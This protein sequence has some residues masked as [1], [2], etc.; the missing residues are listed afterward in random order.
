[1]AYIENLLKSATVG[2]TPAATSYFMRPT[3][4]INVIVL[5]TP[6]PLW[7]ATGIAIGAGSYASVLTH[8]LIFP[9]WA[10]DERW[11]HVGASSVALAT[12]AGGNYEALYAMNSAVPSQIGI[13]K[14][15]GFAI[16]STIA[17]TYIYNSFLRPITL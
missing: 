6:L 1:M 9:A 7:A 3:A 5:K 14:V 13:M 12:I 15:A 8:D 11:R 17:G 10:I 16:G 4:R 2:A